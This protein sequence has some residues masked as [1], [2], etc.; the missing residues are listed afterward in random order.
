M[1]PGRASVVRL[2]GAVLASKT[3]SGQSPAVR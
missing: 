3:T 1:L 2:V